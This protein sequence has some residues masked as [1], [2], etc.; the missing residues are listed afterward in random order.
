MSRGQERER[1]LKRERRIL[2]KRSEPISSSRSVGCLH[3]VELPKAGGVVLPKL[4]LS[5]DR[6]REGRQ[7][8]S[9]VQREGKFRGGEREMGTGKASKVHLPSSRLGGGGRCQTLRATVPLSL[10]QKFDVWWEVLK[11][12]CK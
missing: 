1:K 10:V 6:Q 7:S 12:K 11:S 4:K 3:P 5:L 9:P 2:G 8:T